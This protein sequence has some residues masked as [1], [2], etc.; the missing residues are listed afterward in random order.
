MEHNSYHEV[1]RMHQWW[2]WSLLVLVDLFFLYGFVQQVVFGHPFGDDPAPDALLYVVL[3]VLIALDV[4]TAML[5][6]EIRVDTEG[7]HYRFPPFMSKMRTVAYSELREAYVR[8]YRPIM[9]FGGWGYRLGLPKSGQALNIS[10]DQGLQLV[11]KEGKRLLL[12][13]QQPELL[14]EALQ[15]FQGAHVQS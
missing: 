15:R 7:I 12:G 11:W 1:Q 5:K 3:V 6:L 2:M 4:F 14:Q 13:T 10:G 9:E 8:R